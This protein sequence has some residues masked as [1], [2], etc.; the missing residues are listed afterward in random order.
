MTAHPVG[1]HV[2]QEPQVDP[3]LAFLARASARLILVESGEMDLA[4]AFEQLVQSLSCP[5]TREMVEQWERSSR[6]QKQRRRK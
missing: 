3:R 1:L 4:E 6:P 5:C 2:A